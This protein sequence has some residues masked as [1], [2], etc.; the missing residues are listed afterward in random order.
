MERERFPLRGPILYLWRRV[1]NGTG[2]VELAWGRDGMLETPYIRLQ[3]AMC[4]FWGGWRTL[5]SFLLTWPHGWMI[6]LLYVL[7]EKLV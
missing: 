5:R 4:F 3:R 2:V 6:P 1:C 7:A